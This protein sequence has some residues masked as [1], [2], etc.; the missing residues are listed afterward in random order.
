MNTVTAMIA[1]VAVVA[2]IVL[3]LGVRRRVTGGSHDA[4]GARAASAHGMRQIR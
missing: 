4:D 1:V 3:L 2:V